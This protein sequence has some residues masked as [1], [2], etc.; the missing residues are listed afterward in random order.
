MST[1]RLVKRFDSFRHRHDLWSVW[2]D[3]LLMAATAIS[4]AVDIRDAT[5]ARREAGYMQVVKKYD[6][7]VVDSIC[8]ALGELVDALDAEPGDVLGQTFMALE[9]G[10]KWIG[11]FFTPDCITKVMANTIVDEEMR[12]RIKKH[13]FVTMQEPAVGGGAMVIG[14]YNA[15]RAAGMNP[16]TQL[17]VTAM[18][19]DIKSV[20]MAY[21]QLSLLGVPAVIVHGNTLTLETWD[22][23]YTPAHILHGWE[24]KLRRH[25]AAVL[26]EPEAITEPKPAVRDSAPQVVQRD[27]FGEAA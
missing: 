4:N 11:Q 23:W 27:L 24:F 9:L 16:Q 26:V 8:G 21:V 6:R 1:A 18:D 17:H 22:A 5:R 20:H 7:D 14:I 2:T 19:V 15:M 10:N 13:G 25:R 3:F 12:E